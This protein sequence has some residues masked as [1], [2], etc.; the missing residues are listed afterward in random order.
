MGSWCSGGRDWCVPPLK[1]RGFGN[2]RWGL[3]VRAAAIGVYYHS[4]KF[5]DLGTLGG[6]LVFPQSRLVCAIV[7]VPGIW[8]L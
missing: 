1:F 3:G 5:R 2:F 7:K 4:L 6:V 8:E